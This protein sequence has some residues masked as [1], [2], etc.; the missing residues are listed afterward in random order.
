[1]IRKQNMAAYIATFEAKLKRYEE[2]L[3]LEPDSIFYK[4]L[5]KNTRDYLEELYDEVKAAAPQ[6]LTTTT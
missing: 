3:R 2:E 1:M 5:V 6:S 4:A